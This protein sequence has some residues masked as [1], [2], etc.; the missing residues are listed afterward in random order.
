MKS[1]YLLP[2]LLII[3]A[4]L[5]YFSYNLLLSIYFDGEQV[6]V[7]SY[8]E[9]FVNPL[10]SSVFYLVYFVISFFIFRSILALS[11]KKE[12][13]F[14]LLFLIVSFG[15]LW[16]SVFFFKS[17]AKELISTDGILVSIDDFSAWNYYLSSS[18]LSL[19]VF[20][21]ARKKCFAWLVITFGK[22]IKK[23]LITQVESLD[24]PTW[25]L[26]FFKSSGLVSI[27]LCTLLMSKKFIS[28]HWCYSYCHYLPV[29]H[30][31]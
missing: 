30:V 12:M 7:K 4:I 8:R 15:L 20:V 29:L 22:G 27:C 11:F 13:S 5:G 17:N 23:L 26:F 2:L 9:L 16:L 31:E 10:L 19:L 6:A 21:I 1:I 25:F 3:Y 18:V 24:L 28:F 14:Q